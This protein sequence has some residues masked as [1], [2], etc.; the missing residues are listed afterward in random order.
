MK[1]TVREIVK[2]LLII[3]A[4]LYAFVGV[5]SLFSFLSFLIYVPKQ[6]YAED[7][8]TLIWLIMP[9]LNSVVCFLIFYAFLR[10]KTWGRRLAI[11]Y[12][13]LWLTYGIFASIGGLITDPREFRLTDLPILFLIGVFA[14]LGGS[15]LFYLWREVRELMAA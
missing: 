3:I 15:I 12:N 14:L 6:E 5:T 1:P 4:L 2:T 11:T 8:L 13:G 7:P 10:L 9:L